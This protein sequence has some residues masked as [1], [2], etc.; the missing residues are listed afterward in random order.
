MSDRPTPETDAALAGG[1]SA[2]ETHEM[3]Q[4][5][6]RQRDEAQEQRGRLETVLRRIGWVN[7]RGVPK[8][9]RD[10]DSARKVINDTQ[11]EGKTP[12]TASR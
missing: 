11:R 12:N 10:A 5:L 2:A 4:R 9:S 8:H 1:M 3:L 7:G 6:E